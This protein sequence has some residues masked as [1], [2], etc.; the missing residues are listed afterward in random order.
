M[1]KLLTALLLLAFSPLAHPQA[2][3]PIYCAPGVACSLNGPSATGPGDPLWLA[4]AKANVSA[5]NFVDATSPAFG[6]DPSGVLDSTA[7]INLAF[8][9]QVNGQWPDVYLPPGTYKISNT[10][11]TGHGA[12]LYGTD[13]INTLLEVSSNFNSSATAVIT[14]NSSV[15]TYPAQVAAYAERYFTCVHDLTILGVQPTGGSGTAASAATAGAT[16]LLVNAAPPVGY[17]ISDGSNANFPIPHVTHVVSV[18]GTGPYT[19][20]VD[21]A[22][23]GTVAQGDTLIFNVS[24]HSIAALGSCTSTALGTGCEYPTFVDTAGLALH[25]WNVVLAGGWNCVNVHAGVMFITLTDF[26]CANIGIQQDGSTDYS[27]LSSLRF[28]PAYG[29]NGYESNANADSIFWD[30][31]TWALS[32]GRSDGLS[33]NSIGTFGCGFQ[34]TADAGLS[35]GNWRFHAIYL[36]GPGGIMSVAGGSFMIEGFGISGTDTVGGGYA[37]NQTGGQ[38]RISHALISA[39][40]QWLALPLKEMQ[41]TGSG[42]ELHISDSAWGTGVE[43]NYLNVLGGITEVHGTYVQLVGGTLTTTPFTQTGGALMFF[44][45]YGAPAGASDGAVV[46]IQSDS[47]FNRYSDNNFINYTNVFPTGAV[48]GYYQ[49]SFTNFSANMTFS[50]SGSGVPVTVTNSGGSDAQDVGGT[51]SSSSGTTSYTNS[52]SAHLVVGAFGT[53][54]AFGNNA[55]MVRIDDG[56]LVLGTNAQL[57]WEIS[58]PGLL[59]PLTTFTVALLPACTSYEDSITVVSDAASPAFLTAVTGGGSTR[60]PVFCNGTSWV[61]F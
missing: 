37:Y 7:A 16:T 10:I 58:I 1:K 35:T 53:A 14:S 38:V 40:Q 52:N 33:G 23:T 44:D 54:S 55:G 21:Q 49:T 51:N 39:Q 32:L 61:A 57:N 30:A 31:Q 17:L 29:W 45:N 5:V 60:V 3:Q 48:E 50:G 12:C 20:T 4:F 46:N 9:T 13:R 26:G 27:T 41:I 56:P 34:S 15:A 25:M 28:H 8:S 59:T 19:V 11:T 42:S 24:K 2:H 22:L 6:A 36:D 18:T 43:V 47:P